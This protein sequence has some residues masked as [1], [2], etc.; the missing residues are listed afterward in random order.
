MYLHHLVTGLCVPDACDTFKSILWNMFIRK[1]VG[2][3]EECNP[4]F[5]KLWNVEG[6]ACCFMQ[7][8]RN[9]L[10]MNQH[11]NNVTYIGWMLEVHNPSIPDALFENS[12]LTTFFSKNSS[13]RIL[14]H[15]HMCL[16]WVK[17][18]SVH[19][20][21]HNVEFESWKHPWKIDIT[22][23]HVA[24]VTSSSIKSSWCH[25]LI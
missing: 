8:R 24:E 23:F 4:H 18:E 7:P 11:V 15:K 16:F 9:D 25:L 19:V 12:Y 20:L 2:G 14:R 6:V 13:T 5:R 10:D 3:T 22:L 21:Q 1:H 17:K